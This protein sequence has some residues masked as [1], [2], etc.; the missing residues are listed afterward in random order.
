MDHFKNMTTKQAIHLILLICAVLVGIIAIFLYSAIHS[1][2]PE[3]KNVGLLN[4]TISPSPVVSTEEQQK[5]RKNL[6]YYDT[7]ATVQ[8]QIHALD[9][10]SRGDFEG[11]SDIFKKISN[12]YQANPKAP[13]GEDPETYISQIRHDVA[14]VSNLTADNSKEVF[15]Q[16][17]DPEVIAA[18]MIYKPIQTRYKAFIN[19]DSAV[20]ASVKYSEKN[21][22]NLSPG[23]DTPE[24]LSAELKKA[25]AEGH[26][27]EE[28]SCY[29]MLLHGHY[30]KMYLVR[31]DSLIWHPYSL[32]P[33]KTGVAPFTVQ[34][35]I[36][37]ENSLA[38]TGKKLDDV[39]S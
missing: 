21:S 36:K 3:D 24:E 27:Y 15:S 6:P 12:T 10:L 23:T 9:Y 4:T 13:A 31:D 11:L 26:G 2:N 35:A 22:V 29:R 32:L 37:V 14:L 28:I 17:S 8:L 34:D 20:V 33:E 38:G 39:V 25:N 19:Y 16:L 18:A 30:Y 7:N 5:D 1:E